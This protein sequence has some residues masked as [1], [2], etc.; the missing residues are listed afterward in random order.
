MDIIHQS[1]FEVVQQ[2]ISKTPKDSIMPLKRGYLSQ[3]SMIGTHNDVFLIFN[4][5]FLYRFCLEFLGEDNPDENAL[6]DMAKELANLIVGH[7]KV[8]TQ[9]KGRSFNIS[10]PHYL[11]HRLIKNYDHGLHFRLGSGRC[12]I[13]MRRTH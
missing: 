3:I 2:S 8:I 9:A 10:T 4:K 5:A 1:F 13:Y 11:G 12:S 7:A 6:E